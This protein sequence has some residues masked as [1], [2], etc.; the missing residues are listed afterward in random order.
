MADPGMA[1]M[2]AKGALYSCWH[3]RQLQM[4]RPKT[5]PSS[6]NAEASQLQAPAEGDNAAL[7][8]LRLPCAEPNT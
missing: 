8:A 3:T 5:S 4:S 7:R 2:S 1:T 6:S